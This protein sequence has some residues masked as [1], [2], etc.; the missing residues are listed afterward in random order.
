MV[1]VKVTEQFL[2]NFLFPQPAMR[3]VIMRGFI[4]FERVSLKCI[5]L[6]SSCCPEHQDT[7]TNDHGMAEAILHR[8]LVGLG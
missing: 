8:S 3:L 5:H 2:N 4:F 1:K 6:L 7:R